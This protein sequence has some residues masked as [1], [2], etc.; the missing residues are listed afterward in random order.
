MVGVGLWMPG[1]LG[2]LA[3]S[4]GPGGPDEPAPYLDDRGIG[5]GQVLLGA[6]H[7]RAALVFHH[8]DILQREGLNAGIGEATLGDAV[9]MVVVGLV[10]NMSE[11]AR[12]QLG[13]HILAVL[14]GEQLLLR[15]RIIA[16]A[17]PVE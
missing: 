2:L 4:Q 11:G 15:N 12:N 13:I 17:Q 6:V 3:F 10:I 16:P 7:E 1:R 5:A 8:G 14:V 9:N